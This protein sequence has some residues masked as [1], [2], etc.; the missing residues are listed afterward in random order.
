MSWGA[1]PRHGL[2]P[3]LVPS[4]A[5]SA[6]DWIVASLHPFR[7][8]TAGSLVPPVFA[9]YARILYPARGA[10]GRLVRWSE[11]AGWSGRIYHP[12]MQFEPLAT[13]AEGGGTGPKPW[14]GY[15]PGED[16]AHV[17]ALAKVLQG[18]TTTPDR[19]WYCVWEG[20]GDVVPQSTARVRR[21][22][23]DYLLYAGTL[24]ALDGGRTPDYWFPA[25]RSW[26]VAGDVDLCWCYVGGS[27]AC[28]DAILGCPDLEAVPAEPDDGLTYDSD[29]VNLLTPEQWAAWN[30]PPPRGV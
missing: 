23:R 2:S 4:E 16:R 5:T 15:A 30:V 21:Q 11:V 28:V 18:H 19:I 12:R 27:R 14:D 10:G 29:P 20:Y 17:P 25:D 9:A 22:A 26:C 13:P 24:A 8:G 6:A 1:W 3:R 7:C